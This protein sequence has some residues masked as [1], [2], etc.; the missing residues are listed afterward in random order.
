M[1]IESS[2][3]PDPGQLVQVRNLRYVVADV[4][5]GTMTTGP[6]AEGMHHVQHL[7]SLTSIED[8]A[9][10]EELRVVWELETGA[11]VLADANLADLTGYDAPAWLDA[12]LDAVHWGAASSVDIRAL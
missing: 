9:L 12:Y 2:S 10:G 11:R 7:I 8:D 6:L 1:T 5:R 3:L 4:N